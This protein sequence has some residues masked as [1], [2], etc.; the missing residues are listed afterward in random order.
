[1]FIPPTIAIWF[2]GLWIFD[3]IGPFMADHCYSTVEGAVALQRVVG[4]AD[5]AAAAVVAGQELEAVAA[6]VVAAAARRKNSC[7]WEKEED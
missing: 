2:P 5:V 4:V 3:M 6:V 7:S 1:M